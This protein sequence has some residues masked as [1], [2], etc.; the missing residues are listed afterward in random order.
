MKV[1][2]PKCVC[3]LLP[4]PDRGPVGGGKVVYEYANRFARDGWK[5]TL[6]YAVMFSYENIFIS[7]LRH[8]RSTMMTLFDVLPYVVKQYMF[9]VKWFCIDK[10]IGQRF[11]LRFDINF[12]KRFPKGTKFVATYVTTAPKL[13]N[14]VGI[15][16]EDKYYFIQ[17]REDWDVSKNEVYETYRYPITKIAI[18]K[19][20]IEGIEDAGA[21]AY[22]VPN[23]L[24][25]D[26]FKMTNPIEDRIS[27]E[28]AM[29][30]HNDDRKRT[31]DAVAALKIVR[32][33]YPEL[34]VTAFGVPDKPS[35]LPEWITYVQKPNKETHNKIYNNAA[36][37]VASSEQEG[38]GL[39]PC[40]AMICGAAVA[41]TDIGGYRSFAENEVNAL[42]SPVRDPSTLAK[43]IC[44]L[45][46]D[47]NLRIRIAKTGNVTIKKF[48][49]DNS[50]AKMKSL[51]ERASA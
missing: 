21:N 34:H 43:N 6:A 40:E 7:L 45:I 50:F 26:Y 8:P 25:F 15:C 11:S 1:R 42:M 20:I 9:G 5:V 16:N 33:K 48:T 30:W 47:K 35:D 46:E 13:M 38:W 51:L 39:T 36:I 28:V 3:F 24:D 2:R 41:C 10:R 37:F 4:G 32:E 23:G 22:Y 12:G 19:W 27:T 29:L 49:W 44:R 17:G 18:S 31:E 14:F